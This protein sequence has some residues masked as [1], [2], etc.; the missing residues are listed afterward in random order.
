MVERNKATKIKGIYA[1]STPNKW[2]L[3]TLGATETVVGSLVEAHVALEA[4]R[5]RLRQPVQEAAKLTVGACAP[6]WLAD[7]KARKPN[8]KLPW[9]NDRIRILEMHVLPYWQNFVIED[10]LPRDIQRWQ[11]WL[12]AQ[13]QTV[14]RGGAA[15]AQ[16]TLNTAWSTFR[17]LF[18]WGCIE[19]NCANPMVGLKFKL[20]HGT[21]P[22]K[23]YLTQEELGRMLAALRQHAAPD[24]YALIACTFATGARHAEVSAWHW[25]EIDFGQGTVKITRSQ[26]D[27]HVGDPKTEATRRLIYLPPQV[28]ELL[29]QHREWQRDHGPRLPSCAGSKCF[30]S[31]AGQY[32]HSSVVRKPLAAACKVAGITKH[33][34][35][36]CARKTANNLLLEA[37]D[38]PTTRAIIGHADEESSYRYHGA[39]AE[40]RRAATLKAFGGVLDELA[41]G[42]GTGPEVPALN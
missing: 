18:G 33:L 8:T 4:L 13:R 6:L 24:M 2:V 31:S 14:K 29:R 38:G 10:V 41:L 35:A 28:V 42:T 12:G 21:K 3:R 17:T 1:T 7:I 27:G 16:G 37:T 5:S 26:V 36:H 23:D 20:T 39:S 32:R 25:E 30:P 40:K 9:F 11:A 15:Y 22:P 34:T 19:A